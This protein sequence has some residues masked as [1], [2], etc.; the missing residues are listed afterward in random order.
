MLETV[1][2]SEA[3]APPLFGGEG[4]GGGQC[5]RRGTDFLKK[6]VGRSRNQTSN[7]VQ[8]AEH[9]A[10]IAVARCMHVQRR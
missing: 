3:V 2:R 8:I 1:T 5:V 10:C 7:S 6:I 4:S 9:V